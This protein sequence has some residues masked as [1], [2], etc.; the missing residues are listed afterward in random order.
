MRIIFQ[1]LFKYNSETIQ[2]SSNK[3]LFS[4][5]AIKDTERKAMISDILTDLEGSL[6]THSTKY[7]NN[8]FHN[9]SLSEKFIWFDWELYLLEDQCSSQCLDDGLERGRQQHIKRFI[10]IF[11]KK[12]PIS[13]CVCVKSHHDPM[14]KFFSSP[15]RP[16]CSDL[17]V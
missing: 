15:H 13:L 11:P 1:R 2:F 16:I 4:K 6:K 14:T 3:H 10:N 12:S 9:W 17:N 5:I 7:S 8:S